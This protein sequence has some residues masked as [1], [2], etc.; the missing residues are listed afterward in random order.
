MSAKYR[1]LT[2][3]QS[4]HTE[5]ISELDYLNWAYRNQFQGTAHIV[6]TGFY[7]RNKT[8]ILS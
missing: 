6:E 8:S 5:T 7:G 2:I 3:I 1:K 4:V